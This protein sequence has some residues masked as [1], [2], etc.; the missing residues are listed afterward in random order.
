MA[1]LLCFSRTGFG[2]SLFTIHRKC[3]IG[4]LPV[5]NLGP[6]INVAGRRES[7]GLA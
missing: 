7:E 4:H 1:A 2:I 5:R 3:C 6:E